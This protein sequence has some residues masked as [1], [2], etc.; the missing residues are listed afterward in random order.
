MQNCGQDLRHSG[1]KVMSDIIRI[2]RSIKVC[3][4]VTRGRLTLVDVAGFA[5]YVRR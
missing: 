2:S 4:A 3:P 5:V 1:G